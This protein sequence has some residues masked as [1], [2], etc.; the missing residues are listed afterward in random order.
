MAV[1]GIDF[2]GEP[3]VAAALDRAS[4]LYDTDSLAA[5]FRTRV[6]RCADA[7]SDVRLHLTICR[8]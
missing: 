3:G 2:A 5:P 6:M 8:I 4:K 7:R 1:S